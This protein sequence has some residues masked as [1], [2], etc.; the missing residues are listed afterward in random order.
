MR[1]VAKQP[2]R[3]VARLQQVLRPRPS[4]TEGEQ[5]IHVRGG[6]LIPSIFSWEAKRPRENGAFWSS[7]AQDWTRT[8]TAFR[9]HAPQACV[10]TNF[11]TW[12]LGRHR[13]G[14]GGQ[15]AANIEARAKASES[16]VRPGGSVAWIPETQ[17][18]LGAPCGMLPVPFQAYTVLVMLGVRGWLF[19]PGIVVEAVGLVGGG[20]VAAV[21]CL[22]AA[23][24]FHIGPPSDGCRA[25]MRTYPGPE[26]TAIPNR[27]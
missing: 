20:S 7:G 22:R 8:S 9:P 2:R 26:A 14:F 18:H 15:G 19:E 17:G 6:L 16:T 1:P 27:R 4:R 11:T 5:P 25:T 23:V 24:L 10:S 13:T 21:F 3:R 12:A